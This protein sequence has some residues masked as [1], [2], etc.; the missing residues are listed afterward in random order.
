VKQQPER[1]GSSAVLHRRRRV[2]A[3]LLAL[4]T[5]VVCLVAPSPAQAQVGD[6]DGT[7]TSAT[8]GG[9]LHG[10]EVDLYDAN[11][12]FQTSTTTGIDGTYSFAEVDVGTYEIGFTPGASGLNVAPQ[13]AHGRATLEAA[14]PV[15]VT[16]DQ[17]TTV[18]AALAD[19]G[20][21]TGAVSDGSGGVAGMDVEVFD[22]G[23]DLVGNTV[24]GDNGAYT[25]SG[26][27]GGSYV[28]RFSDPAGNLLA[29]YYRD[30]TSFD[31]AEL[32]A[33][34]AGQATTG[35]DQTLPTAGQ[36]TGHVSDGS[37]TVPSAT[38]TLYSSDGSPLTQTPPDDS[39][40]Y[41]FDG[42]DT[43]TYY[44]GFGGSDYAPQFF[45]DKPTLATATPI[46]VRAGSLPVGGVD[47]VLE[48]GGQISGV[49]TEAS[50]PLDGAE[51]DLY[52]AAGRM[53]DQT[54]TDAMG[55][56]SFS[57]L[58][59]GGYKVGFA[60]GAGG[61]DVAPQFYNG[62]S[63]LVAADLV[64][65]AGGND[66]VASMDLSPGGSIAGHVGDAN[67]PLEGV[68]VEAFDSDG[69]F[70]SSTQT[71]ADGSY[72]LAGL[73]SGSYEIGFFD[74]SAGYLAQYAHGKPSL[75]TADP[76]TVTAPAPTQ[77]VDATLVLGGTIRGKV[78]NE[79]TQ[80]LLPNAF[81]EVFDATGREA[82]SAFTNS[83]GFYTIPGLRPGTYRVEFFPDFNSPDL[84]PQFYNG[85]ATLAGAQPLTIAPGTSLS[86][87]DGHLT[88]TGQGT[89][90]GMVTDENGA[91]LRDVFVSLYAAG[92]P[93]PV[94][95]A[96]TNSDGVYSLTGVSAG[97][98]KVGF[99]LSGRV[100]QFWDHQPSLALATPIALA[101]GGSQGG[102]DAQ[103]VP[104]G[105]ITGTVTDSAGNRVPNADVV[106]YDAGG[107]P[108]NSTQTSARGTYT[109]GPL[110]PGAYEV[111][112]SASGF[113]S[114]FYSGKASIVSANP[115][116]VLAGVATTGIDATLAG[117]ATG[118]GTIAGEVT[119]SAGRPLDNAIVTVY[120]AGGSFFD[121]TFTA[122]DGSYAVTNLPA[123]SY[124]VGFD[125]RADGNQRDI[126]NYVPQFYNGKP[127]LDVADPVAVT[128]G[129][130]THGID[131]AL[132]I[133][134]VITGHVKDQ[135]GNAL[136]DI[137]VQLYDSTHAP[138]DS[139]V[140]DNDGSYTFPGLPA[141]T[142]YVGYECCVINDTAVPF[143]TNDNEF[144]VLPQFYDGKA[145]LTDATP[146]VIALGETKTLNDA[147]LA[148]GGRITGTVSDATGPLGRGIEVD[149]YD[150]AG[151]QIDSVATGD[152]GTY[153][154]LGLE[155]GDYNVGFV[156]PSGTF[157][158]QFFDAQPTL[159]SPPTVHVDA[160]AVHG[161][162]DA[163]LGRAGA[164]S[165]T[166][167]DDANNPQGAVVVTVYDAS[168]SPVASTQTADDGT[169]TVSPLPASTEYRVGFV[170]GSPT[171][172]LLAQFFDDKG[173][174]G[175]AD[176][177][178]V[179]D[180]A[181][182]TGIDAQLHAGARITGTVTDAASPAHPLG[183]VV[184]TLYDA[185][186]GN[187]ITTTATDGAGGYE[188]DG[189]AGGGTYK[190][191]F[192]TGPG[193]ANYV[194][195]FFDGASTLAD[196]TVLTLTAGMTRP[197]VDAHLAGGGQ[198]SGTV[199]DTNGMPL[200]GVL[201]T[202]YDSNGDPV[203]AVSTA[204]DGTY[205][206]TKLQDG[207]FTVQF[208]LAGYA[209]QFWDDER[210]V[211]DPVTIDG[212]T[213]VRGIDATLVALQTLALATQVAPATIVVGDFFRDTATLATPP[214]G[215][216]TP[217]G[218]VTFT[219]YSD[220]ACTSQVFTSTNGL[221][222]AGATATSSAFTPSAPGTY[223]VIAAYSGD[224]SYGTA[225]TTCAD[226]AE[227]V[228]VGK[229]TVTVA[230]Q[231]APASIALGASFQDTAA[232][233]A[234][235]EGVP[236]P[237][238]T[239]TFDV[240][241]SPTCSGSPL[242]TSTNPVDAA[243]ATAASSS[244]TPAASG[245]YRVI[246]TYNG[247]ANYAGSATACADP[248]EAVTVGQAAVGLSTQV[249]PAAIALG[250]S[251]HDTATLGAPPAGA[252]APTGTV[253]FKVYG[254]PSCVAQVFTST[255][256]I[257]GAGTTAVSDDFTP[258]AAGT[259]RVIATYSGDPNYA[260]TSTACADATEAVAVGAASLGLSTQ[261]APAA[262]ALGASFHDTATLAAPPAGAA[263]P[264]GSVR[265][266]VYGTASC[267][268]TPAFT[269]T[270]PLNPAGTTAVSS[271]FMPSA[272]GTYR[273]IAS[274]SGDGNYAG[275]A[276]A[277]ADPAEAVTVGKATVGVTTQVA[278]AG[279]TLGASFHDTATL[280]AP[281]AGA[282]APTGSVTFR[283][284]S[285]AS[286]VTQVLTSTNPLNGA[287]TTAV[288]DDFTP[289]TAG[290]YHVI[291]TYGGDASYA[292]SATACADAVETV[293]VNN[294]PAPAPTVTGLSPTSGPAAGGTTVTIDGA[295]LGGTTAV[296]F[297]GHAA[298]AVTVLSATQLTATAPA[299][300][301]AVDVTVTTADGTSATAAADV[302]TY[303]APPPPPPG[304]PA[305]LG[306][307]PASGSTA[308]G[309]GVVILGSNL[310]GAT[311][312][313]FGGHVASIV[314]VNAAGTRLTVLA[315]AGTGTVDVVVTTPVG[316]SPTSSADIYTYVVP[317]PP[318]SISSIA[319]ITGP[320][321]G[322]TSVTIA[323][324]GFTG[325]TAVSF[326]AVA[327][328]GFTVDSPTQITAT[329][330]AG[331]GVVAITVTGPG[332]TSATV[333]GGA[334]TY[335]A[336]S[337]PPSGGGTG[338]PVV[339]TGQPASKAGPPKVLSSSSAE[340]TATINPSGLPTTMHF[341]YTTASG[342]AASIAAIVYASQ[343]PEQTVGS[344]FVDHTVTAKV[345]G[346][347]PNSDYHVRAVA[348]NPSGTATSGDATFTTATDP[349]PPPPVLGKSFNAEPV[350]GTV[351]VLLPGQG[352]VSEVH[353]SA[354]KGVGFIPL[355]EAR[356]LPVG[357]VFDTTAGVAR[358]TT[359]TAKKGATQSGNF[360][361]GL[362]KLLQNRK[363]KGL[364][365][366][367]LVIRP[368]A[369]KTCASAGKL[370][371]QT[372]AKKAL[373]KA[374]LTL[375]RANAKGRF[376]TR[377]RYS[378]ATVRGTQW[379]TSDRCDGTFTKV[380]RGVVV[381]N[382]IRRH[383]QVVLRAGK[384]YLAKKP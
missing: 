271:N 179:V 207:T 46:V 183:D 231:V 366:L 109:A 191:G 188:F 37:S 25:V 318:P 181:T 253:M 195:Q 84:A 369:T 336:P 56:Y 104:G 208:V 367:S 312:V 49:V 98:Y 192:D 325:A 169:Y 21:I 123:G 67:G 150:A 6:I 119:D 217:T 107:V 33:V 296:A 152:D 295:N 307:T 194:P 122:S 26:L 268:G 68:S 277:C 247:D 113:A 111:Q 149:L 182:T 55:G 254:D 265:F 96:S 42:L 103:L 97:T 117:A 176:A 9:P 64:T 8:T 260:A 334:F 38:V 288:S 159:P 357:T 36:I 212:A 371:A 177:V 22:A 262:I 352:H 145:T 130:T 284:Y 95:F 206:E 2:G 91:A 12:Q 199:T 132:D 134:G 351:Y 373:P 171:Q 257:D 20:Q 380:Q 266:D 144:N 214:S 59:D 196:A 1:E 338:Q 355:T 11:G 69:N 41:S 106:V 88:A 270:N 167:T 304:P 286:C 4:A 308:G 43:G 374:V 142:Y 184:V 223:R 279:V 333:A 85:S 121:E 108:V 14:D 32:V 251:F 220:A 276:T 272:A 100:N 164:I 361:S 125:A 339:P 51:V 320:G 255:N 259:Y 120:D 301:G 154:L 135:A 340:F 274:Y 139:T 213:D 370:Q 61:S 235:P 269:S 267:T 363:Q 216:P 287:G 375:L 246:A 329:A 382:N 73:A 290:T 127:T 3:L 7:V 203:G 99:Q 280:G 57:G 189:L 209:S 129:A 31:T 70:V 322:G 237:T 5:L 226:P 118:S 110:A 137:G 112:F 384:S 87:I 44:V 221:D 359:A 62:K 233:G 341:E 282:A 224:A 94:A 48:H 328:A 365:E 16:F 378:S 86:G 263:A 81:V 77:N 60:A 278:P 90:S 163:T 377:G 360:G 155:T 314:G 348:T 58:A 319:P 283:V 234:G 23:G 166:V 50:V 310:D 131:A 75:A 79:A 66:A 63:T 186:S 147:V 343:T 180:G 222:A 80:Q 297:G 311:Q 236:V 175:A 239:V 252:A 250:A 52:D 354:A 326:G 281:P 204:G 34:T 124:R 300:S 302:Y 230:T 347:V 153:E 93:D 362:F 210:T 249:A 148:P 40:D 18:D 15:V 168:G 244:F 160:G 379:S 232:L 198:I 376:Q 256:P 128:A 133:G 205:T 30:R 323:G 161:G 47:A 342:A 335:V 313:A 242:F 215:A 141:G 364:A 303:V 211:G 165:G 35:I 241:S 202:V 17:T 27:A 264:T 193:G 83:D 305:V 372:A 102:I 174:F 349:P 53:I 140:T 243:G 294:P 293:T 76:V 146:I 72:T 225:T 291:A 356:Q 275:S 89:I 200:S 185:A 289:A 151:N 315:P 172:N 138:L 28:V 261:V 197:G 292:A 156:D 317:P 381:V 337:G 74:S 238:G 190:V 273:V 173:S 228:T 218:N 136:R 330:P 344:D 101:A 201:V 346:L 92:R 358:L 324:S 240:F 327:A 170:P 316:T 383:R 306:V 321:A 332:G 187:A 219:V 114:Q 143:N 178:T 39:G 331:S 82:G 78:L 54:Q 245:T 353:T 227:V 65:I 309:N 45:D 19:G 71:A 116:D 158:S 115:V 229:A 105:T 10:V 29:R 285:D 13:F 350:S 157:A 298:T 368:G 258:S 162:V 24:S 126:G 345:A 299:G 248:A